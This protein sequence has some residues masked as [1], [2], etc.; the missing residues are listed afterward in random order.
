M[1]ELV[2]IKTSWLACSVIQTTSPGH[3]HSVPG[4]ASGVAV[5]LERAPI[6]ALEAGEDLIDLF[7]DGGVPLTLGDAG[8][9]RGD[10]L[11]ASHTEP[12][13]RMVDPAHRFFRYRDREFG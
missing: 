5:V 1:T 6:L 10:V 12:F 9:N 2:T 8:E 11:A 4:V 7:R 3:D 13:R